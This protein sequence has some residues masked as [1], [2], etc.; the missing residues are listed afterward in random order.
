MLKKL[1]RGRRQFIGT[2][3]NRVYVKS[4]LA[5]ADN[6]S[7]WIDLVTVTIDKQVVKNI[8]TEGRMIFCSW[9]AGGYSPGCYSRIKLNEVPGQSIGVAGTGSS[10]PSTECND[11]M[12]IRSPGSQTLVFQVY[13]STVGGMAVAEITVD[14]RFV[15]NAR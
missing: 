10:T 11:A 9:K 4:A 12:P 2:E 3:T 14:M 13:N 6:V 15:V 8:D 5:P 7:G 1:F